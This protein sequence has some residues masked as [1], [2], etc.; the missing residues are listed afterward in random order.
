MTRA[1]IRSTPTPSATD[2]PGPTRPSPTT[3]HPWAAHPWAPHPWAPRPWARHPWAWWG[4]ALGAAATST[5]TTNPLLL[6]LVLAVVAVVVLLCRT[7]APWARSLRVYLVVAGAIIV[8]RVALMALVGGSSDEGIVLV[9]LPEW[10]LPTWMAGLRL[11]G[12]VTLNEVLAASYDGLRLGTLMVCVGAANA[13]ANPRAALKSVPA[14]LNQ[15]SVAVVIALATAPQLIES[16]TR[17]RRARRLRG[18]PA[19]GLR[20]VPSLLVPVLEDGLERSLRLAT[21]MESRGYGRRAAR[22]S[23]AGE[24]VLVVALL[25]LVLFTYALFALPQWGAWSWVGL[26]L[27]VAGVALG[28]HL[29]GRGRSTTAYRPQ[30]WRG[31]DTALVASGVAAAVITGWFAAASPAV[32]HP[33]TQPLVWPSLP[34]VMLAVTALLAVPAVVGRRP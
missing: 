1:A 15:L 22:R 31:R 23:R 26:G 7:D 32:M 28:F 5:F 3:P 2:H 16:M 17:V 33:S 19:R 13:L 30:P 21:A 6:A 14:A 29:G 34:P 12:P 24:V 9:R 4:W 11:G 8:F 20:A 27:A 25:A 10:Q 18:R